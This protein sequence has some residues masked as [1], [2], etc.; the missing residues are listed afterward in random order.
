MT[1]VKIHVGGHG[2]DWDYSREDGNKW[3]D[4]CQEQSLAVDDTRVRMDPS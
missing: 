3:A 4:V 1:V 2:V